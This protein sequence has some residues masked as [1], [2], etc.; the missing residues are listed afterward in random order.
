MASV[1]ATLETVFR[2]EYGRV[3]A[4]L[5]RLA[6]DFQVAEDCLMDA[7]ESA[8]ASWPT[9]G[10]PDNPG[11]WLTAAARRKALDRL[12]RLKLRADRQ[13]DVEAHLQALSS[14]QPV[15]P[16]TV[17]DNELRLIFTCC[18]PAL[19]PEA[20][21]ALTLRTLLGMQTHEIARA[22]LV[23]ESTMAQ[24]LVRAKRKIALAGIPYEVPEGS[25]LGPRVEAVLAV[26][27]L[28][29]NEGYAATD[30]EALVR[31]ALCE[32][33]ID[34]G[35]RLHALLP[36]RAEVQGLLALM[37][38]IHSRREA[39]VDAAGALVPLEEQARECWDGAAI[40]EGRALVR[41]AL[42]RGQPGTYA[43]QA[44]IAALHAEATSAGDTDW[45]QICALYTLLEKCSPTPVVRL[46]RAVAVAMV[47]GPEVGLQWLDD[48][49]LRGALDGYHLYHAARADLLR[50][51]Q[52]A[53]QAREA[54]ERALALARN[55]AERDYLRSRLEQV[56]SSG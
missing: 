4:S 27:Y 20:R 28:V 3:L 46:N 48:E 45:P 25:E 53:G 39:R 42:K 14:A 30:G 55:G 35:R 52:R 15:Q 13:P 12:R 11:A 44:A 47:H 33:A 6:G 34:L 38:L 54:Y 49:A 22:F 56:V 7:L 29:F 32:H 5:I 37:L 50:R 26:V 10:V 51:L 41:A 21:V 24:R 43:L 40:E 9:G 19:A 17:A 16:G 18:H 1:P 23:F 2:Q 36:E 8:L 31:R